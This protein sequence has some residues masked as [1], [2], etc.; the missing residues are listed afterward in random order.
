M[1]IEYLM[2]VCGSLNLE[3]V[4]DVYYNNTLTWS[5]KYIGLP[6]GI[7]ENHSIKMFTI[8]TENNTC[9]IYLV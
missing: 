7:K 1:S 8:D 9:N 4:F 3:T 2:N 6:D 5:N